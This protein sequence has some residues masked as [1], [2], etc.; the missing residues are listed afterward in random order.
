MGA[1]RNLSAEFKAKEK[2][3]EVFASKT[4]RGESDRAMEPQR[5][6]IKPEHSRIGRSDQ[7]ISD[8]HMVTV[9]DVLVSI[10]A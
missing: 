2:L 3:P 4:A 10:S 5:P 9:S 6:R 1:R 8:V 7:A